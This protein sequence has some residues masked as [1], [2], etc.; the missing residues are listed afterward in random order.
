VA[1]GMETAPSRVGSA[2]SLGTLF[3]A[4]PH[5]VRRGRFEHATPSPPA[6]AASPLRL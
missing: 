6:C 5:P 4:V 3:R 2:R 1:R